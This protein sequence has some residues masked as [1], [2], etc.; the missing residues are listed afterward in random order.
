MFSTNLNKPKAS[1][2]IGLDYGMARIG[3]SISDE[4]KIIATP[5]MTIQAHKKSEHTAVKV[6]KD[7]QALQET[8]GFI[9]EEIVIG[10]PLLLNG[11]TGLLADEV[12]HFVELLRKL[13]PIP[14]TLWDERLT[15][16]Q[17]ERSLREGTMSRKQRSKVVD[18]VA[19]VILLQS[20]LDSKLNIV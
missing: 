16:V 13:T 12:K 18:S 10:L 2:I 4:R 19:A 7:L 11:K 20:Y 1:R 6:V 15:T 8:K 14:V 5:L 9:I 3:V 17:A